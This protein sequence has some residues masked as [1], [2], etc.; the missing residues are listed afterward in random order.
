MKTALK[1][2]DAIVFTGIFLLAV[3]YLESQPNIF[4]ILS[5]AAM[6]YVM[7]RNPDVNTVTLISIILLARVLDSIIFADYQSLNVYI[8]Y[9]TIAAANAAMVLVVWV[10]P[11][12][13]AK[14]GP[15]FVRKNPRLT[16][17]HQDSMVALL[18]MA[19]TVLALLMLGEHTIRHMD[20]LDLNPM[21]IYN[22]YE[23]IY[24]VLTV[25]SMAVL[26]FMTFEKSK[27]RSN[28]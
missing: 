17:T 1:F 12:L 21:F 13:V 24:L 25:L 28:K 4:D 26:Y 20:S 10:R 6:V 14:Y 11:L 15:K 5:I 22:A 7:I 9:I 2:I 19:Y 3:K 18:Y 27:E 16:I 8:Y 23:E